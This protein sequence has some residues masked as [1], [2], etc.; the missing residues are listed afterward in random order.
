MIKKISFLMLPLDPTIKR[1]N[2]NLLNSFNSI[3]SDAPNAVDL[4]YFM[5]EPHLRKKFKSIKRDIFNSST[6]DRYSLIVFIES[7]AKTVSEYM[8]SIEKEEVSRYLPKKEYLDYIK[9]N[10]YLRY[11]NSKSYKQF[12]SSET[13]RNYLKTVE[14]LTYFGTESHKMYCEYL[15]ILDSEVH[16]KYL[17]YQYSSYYQDDK[18]YKDLILK[19]GE[20]FTPDYY[21]SQEYLAYQENVNDLN[22][23]SESILN[24]YS[25]IRVG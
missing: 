21:T 6:F 23:L 4:D 18:D 16:K 10:F 22:L 2:K 17:Q 1:I 25:N 12:I 3:P 11:K 19:D 8:L 5:L 15:A 9:S 24:R 14:Y 7:N 20:N 13:Y